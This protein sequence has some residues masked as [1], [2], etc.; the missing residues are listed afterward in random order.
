MP[1]ITKT[2]A[3]AAGTTGNNTHA[4]VAVD[5]VTEKIAFEFVVEAA[6][7]TPTVTYKVQATLDAP[8]VVDA[9]A[10]WFDVMLLPAAS[11]TAVATDTKTAVG[12]YV[13]Y[14]AQAHTRFAR[15]FR[16]VT[17]LNTNITYRANLHQQIK[18]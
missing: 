3:A 12:A 5:P 1:T 8:S 18:P 2:P 7:G 4:G 9:S 14:L 15:R 13:Y 10:N 16:V 6:G 11:E 17:S